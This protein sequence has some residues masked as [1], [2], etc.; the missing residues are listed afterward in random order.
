MTIKAFYR[1]LLCVI[2]L[3]SL[4]AEVEPVKAEVKNFTVNS[5]ADT[6][7]DDLTDGDCED[8]SGK[9]TLRAAMQE[10][11]LYYT[12][13]PT[14]TI[15][16]GFNLPDPHTIVLED[17]LPLLY[18]NV[19]N[20][21]LYRVIIDGD[22]EYYGFT[23]TAAST[24]IS[25]LQLQN[26]KN[27]AIYN[28]V[29]GIDLI[30]NNIIIKTD[31]SG[32][33][34]GGSLEHVGATTIQSNFIGYDPNEEKARGNSQY[35]IAIV[36]EESDGSG[37][38]Y[39]GGTKITEGNTISGNDG[40][41]I[42]IDSSSLSL[43]TAIQGNYIG[44][45]DFGSRAV[46]NDGEGIRV[47]QFG[48]QLIIG[49]T[50]EVGNLISGNF[51]HG[52][53]I[54]DATAY[55]LVQG[56]TFGT[57]VDENIYLPNRLGDIS[58]NDSTYLTI[59]GTSTDFGNVLMDGIYGTS[60]DHPISRLEIRGNWIGLSRTGLLRSDP[61]A[62]I[63]IELKDV[64]NQSVISYNK[65]TKFSIG[66]V[67]S[68]Q[69]SSSDIAILNNKIY[70]NSIMGIDLNNDGVTP[71]DV[72]DVDAGPNGLQNFPIISNVE[73][74]NDSGGAKEVM[75]DL[76][77]GAAPSTTYRLQVFSSPN[78]SISGY[79]EGKQIFYSTDVT[80]DSNGY[81]EINEITDW[82]PTNIIGPCLTATATLM[83][84]KT[85]VATSE[86]SP[87]ELAWEPEPEPEPEPEKIFLPMILR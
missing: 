8:S 49:G 84:L 60:I 11:G 58:I 87:G 29:E 54:Q 85:P 57:N 44:T 17:D 46:P 69:N 15:N 63:G 68:N 43:S 82:Y 4:F 75:F 21:N 27:F 5:S 7:D 20:G 50:E 41:G 30:T 19:I 80:T 13:H 37:E 35:G 73:L 40:S 14:D 77:L 6:S 70:N 62:S 53:T 34:L 39:I 74:L 3:L 23:G 51:M 24:T 67:V 81:Y 2:L 18:A 76:S 79:G 1:V 66:I 42:L 83:D 52:M 26:F 10:A 31:G 47:D 59:G 25:G 9:C 48:G 65:I 28:L 86:F 78:C 16:I 56:N 45:D 36:S 12:V 22:Y 55:T 38:I 72:S 71:N 32:I 33:V 61:Y 64:T